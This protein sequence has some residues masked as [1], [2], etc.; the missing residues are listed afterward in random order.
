MEAKYL[1]GGKGEYYGQFITQYLYMMHLGTYRTVLNICGLQEL[2]DFQDSLVITF[3]CFA[4]AK[5]R[6]INAH[7]EKAATSDHDQ[8]LY[9]PGPAGHWKQSVAGLVF[10]LCAQASLGGFTPTRC[11]ARQA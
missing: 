11:E 4:L 5:I 2:G 10:L 9:P 1:E 8:S 7:K 3:Y 6:Q